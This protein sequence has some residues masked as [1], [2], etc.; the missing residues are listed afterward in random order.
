MFS[1]CIWV[2][3]RARASRR[4]HGNNVK[5]LSPSHLCFQRHIVDAVTKGVLPYSVCHCSLFLTVSVLCM[6]V[7]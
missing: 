7:C 5:R 3:M 6:C 2:K 4:M 1:G